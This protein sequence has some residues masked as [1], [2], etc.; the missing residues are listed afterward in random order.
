[1]ARG[2]VGV[3]RAEDAPAG[4]EY[5]LVLRGG[6]RALSLQRH[7]PR[8]FVPG[9]QGVRVVAAQDVTTGVEDFPVSCFGFGPPPLRRGDPG[10]L[11]ACR[12]GVGVII[13][14]DTPPGHQNVAKCL[15]GFCWPSQECCLPRQLVAHTQAC[16]VVAAE[17]GQNIESPAQ[18]LLTGRYS[19]TPFMCGSYLRCGGDQVTEMP[20]FDLAGG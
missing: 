2:R 9:G 14:E 5:L 6:S 10:Q 7:G 12:E 1:M 18:Q 8:E 16:H 11:V 4:I 13:A 20:G 17:T 3:I 19:A 15:L